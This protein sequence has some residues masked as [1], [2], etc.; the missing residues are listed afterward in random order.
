MADMRSQ[1]KGLLTALKCQKEW[2]I[3]W[4]VGGDWLSILRPERGG[5][6]WLVDLK[7]EGGYIKST[8]K[9]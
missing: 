8:T 7:V 5:G 1:N 4:L 9:K 6:G 3:V 2:L